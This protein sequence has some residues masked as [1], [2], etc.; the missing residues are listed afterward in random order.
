[1]IEIIL[2]VVLG[3]I[4]VFIGWYIMAMGNNMIVL[5]NKLD[6]LYKIVVADKKKKR[7]TKKTPIGFKTSATEAEI[8]SKKK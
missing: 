8:L 4:Q 5:N 7:V 1:M 2:I 3:L 6:D